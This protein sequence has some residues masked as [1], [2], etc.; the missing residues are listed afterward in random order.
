M[1]VKGATTKL[2]KSLE[3]STLLVKMTDEIPFG[4]PKFFQVERVVAN[5]QDGFVCLEIGDEVDTCTGC[6]GP[7]LNPKK[8]IRNESEIYHSECAPEQQEEEEDGAA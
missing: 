6:E 2:L 3:T 7:I 4:L 5:K 1:K 8:A